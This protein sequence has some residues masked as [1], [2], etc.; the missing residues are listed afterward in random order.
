MPKKKKP[1]KP[2]PAPK[3]PPKAIK[4]YARNY[5]CSH[6]NSRVNGVTR[7][8]SGIY[9][10]NVGHDDTCPVLRGALTD[11]PDAIRAA[12]AAGRLPTVLEDRISGGE[13]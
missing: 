5:K 12:L 1:R 2:L 3:G 4:D 8:P 13:E 9:H 7:D 11:V 6:C 10:M